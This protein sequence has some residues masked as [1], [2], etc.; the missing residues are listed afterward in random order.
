MI[1]GFIRTLAG[2]AVVAAFA[3]SAAGW[4]NASVIEPPQPVAVNWNRS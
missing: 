1:Q 3:G 4:V 2:A